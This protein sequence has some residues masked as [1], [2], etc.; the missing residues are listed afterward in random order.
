MKLLLFLQPMSS[1]PLWG[2]VRV[3]VGAADNGS[4]GLG[5]C[6]VAVSVVGL[7]SYLANPT[8]ELFRPLAYPRAFRLSQRTGRA[9]IRATPRPRRCSA[10]PA[11]FFRRAVR[12]AAEAD[13]LHA[14]DVAVGVKAG[15]FDDIPLF[16]VVVLF[17]A[18]FAVA[19]GDFVF[20]RAVLAV[21]LEAPCIAIH[22]KFQTRRV[23]EDSTRLYGEA[24]QHR[25]RLSV[26]GYISP[27][28]WGM[29]LSMVP[30][31]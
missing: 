16:V 11:G 24:T 12:L 17:A 1:L 3:R 27:F 6:R 21:V 8:Y 20:Q 18:G 28:W 22:R 15:D 7:R 29:T 31:G 25:M 26:D 5:F 14:L 13:F 19:K 30:S 23:A 4:A 2:R 9:V 10:F